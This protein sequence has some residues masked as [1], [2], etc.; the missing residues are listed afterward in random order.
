MCN[1]AAWWEGDADHIRWSEMGSGHAV[2]P[3]RSLWS[4]VPL[5]CVCVC[6]CSARLE[7]RLRDVLRGTILRSDASPSP[8][9][10]AS[11]CLP[12]VASGGGVQHG[13]TTSEGAYFCMW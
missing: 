8:V 9:S 7:R 3:R 13:V 6:V 4:G 11:F 1:A 5:S 2:R 12:A 10:A